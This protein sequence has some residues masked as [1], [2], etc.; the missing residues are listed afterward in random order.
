MTWFRSSHN[1]QKR[2]KISLFLTALALSAI[3]LVYIVT[4]ERAKKTYQAIQNSHQVIQQTAPILSDILKIESASR[5]FA[6]TGSK[7]FL[8]EYDVEVDRLHADISSLRELSR[9]HPRRKMIVEKLDNTVDARI[10]FANKLIQLR[11]NDSL[12]AAI[13]L[14]QSGIGKSLTESIIS[15]IEEVE[16]EERE[17]LDRKKEAFQLNNRNS[18]ALFLGLTALIVLILAIAAYLILK[19][20]RLR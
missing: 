1:L 9:S 12:N 19:N 5:G 15:L 14:S 8:R 4:L 17:E 3:I 13:I 7:E 20:Y 16:S 6:I 10:S 18:Q 2:I 11:A